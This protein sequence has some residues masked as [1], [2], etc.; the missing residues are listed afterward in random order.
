MRKGSKTGFTLIEILMVLVILG[1]ILGI[2]IPRFLKVRSNANNSAAQA[3]AHNV[4]S[5]L[6]S[7]DMASGVA[8]GSLAGGCE[9]TALQNEGAPTN[10]PQAVAGCLVA[11]SGDHYTVTV[12][13][14]TGTGG[15]AGNGI[16]TEVY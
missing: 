10:P 13:S 5:W 4:V 8:V 2:I 1:T 6:A 14:V 16:F 7:A 3:Y 11:F 9:S 12:T 15:P